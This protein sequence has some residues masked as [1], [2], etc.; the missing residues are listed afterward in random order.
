MLALSFIRIVKF[1]LQDI[2]RNIWLSIVTIT[3]LV[4][5]LF[6]LNMILV[7]KF[8]GETS[9]E[10]VRKKVDMS[11]YFKTDTPEEEIIAIKTQ[12]VNLSQVAEVIYTSKEEALVFFKEKN[13]NNLKILQALREV[14]KN[15]LSASLIIRP[16]NTELSNELI[17][18]LN[19][20]HSDY[21]ESRN[22]ND[23]KLML[24]KIDNIIK[25]ISTAGMFISLIFIFITLLVVFNT[26]R[27]SIYTHRR[28]I[29]I[30]RL[31]GA[32][33]RFVYFPFLFSSLI[34]TF[35][36]LCIAMIIFYL[37]LGLL[38]PYV[39]IFFSGFSVDIISYF[40]SNFIKIFSIE[41]LGMALINVVASLMAVRKYAKV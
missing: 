30:M 28:E 38:R 41:F 21:I 40:N 36:G 12:L 4:L 1:S 15:P 2:W 8:A 26:I 3:I 13:K 7:V 25:K 10:A 39:E 22:F 27:V 31:V 18:R 34:Y 17:A 20:I 14:G 32:S 6:S 19:A 33:K 9:I 37:F 11:I 35:L 5:A 24:A 23:H 29:S 16:K